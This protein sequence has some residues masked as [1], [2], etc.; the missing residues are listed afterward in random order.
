MKR[1]YV[2]LPDEAARRTLL[3]TLLGKN[4]H[5]LR[6]GELSGALVARTAGFSGADIRNLCQEAAMGPMRD[7]GAALFAAG[8]AISEDAIP[9]I[10]FAHFEAALAVTAATVA[11]E[12]LVGYE[13]W[14]RQFGSARAPGG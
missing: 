9:P 12:D 6:D 3:T 4:R 2:P 11:P 10:S 8:G 7:V 1:F 14:N 5:A 13:A